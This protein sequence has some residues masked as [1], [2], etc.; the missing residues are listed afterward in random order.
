MK[1]TI[2]GGWHCS[3]NGRRI[4]CILF[5]FINA[6]TNRLNVFRQ[7]VPCVFFIESSLTSKPYIKTKQIN[8]LQ[9]NHKAIRK[10]YAVSSK[11]LRVNTTLLETIITSS[12]TFWN[13]KYFL[14]SWM[15]FQ[16]TPSSSQHLLVQ[17]QQQ[18]HQKNTRCEI[19]SR[20]KI[21]TPERRKWR[22][23]GVFIVNFEHIKC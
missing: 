1:Y 22:H 3:S 19:C 23:S 16:L 15:V 8:L 6:S 5:S 17:I 12:H 11:Y 13:K 7:Q 21:K 14:F 10:K 18:K 4:F 2:K 9:V 20:L